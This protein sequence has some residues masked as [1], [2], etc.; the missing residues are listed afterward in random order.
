MLKFKTMKIQYIGLVL[1]TLLFF[2]C[3]SGSTS[4]DDDFLTGSNYISENNFYI[5]HLNTEIE[6]LQIEIDALQMLIDSGLGDLTT[7]EDLDDALAE[8]GILE[9]EINEAFLNGNPVFLDPP[10]SECPEPLTCFNAEAIYLVM[11]N[12]FSNLE[13][14]MFDDQGDVIFSSTN[15]ATFNLPG[16]NDYKYIDI[17]IDTYTGPVTMIIEKQ[18]SSGS[19]IY[20]FSSGYAY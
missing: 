20:Y 15:E 7:Q 11:H 13:I 1:M 19:I 10:P 4:S 16:V 2:N 5:Y 3:D 12:R 6:E 14:N 18:D 9:T 8:R 17:A